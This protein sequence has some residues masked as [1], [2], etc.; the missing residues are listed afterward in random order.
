MVLKSQKPPKN[1]VRV[2]VI[3]AGARDH[4]HL[5]KFETYLHKDRETSVRARMLD[6]LWNDPASPAFAGALAYQERGG[7]LYRTGVAVGFT[8]EVTRWFPS[9]VDALG[10]LTHLGPLSGETLIGSLMDYAERTEGDWE[11]FN[12]I[13]PIYPIER[14]IGGEETFRGSVKRL[15]QMGGRV[16]NRHDPLYAEQLEMKLPKDVLVVSFG[17]KVSRRILQ[18]FRD[19]QAKI[20]E[21]AAKA[22][23]VAPT[24][25]LVAA[26]A[27]EVE[28]GFEL[29]LP[30]TTY[31][32][33]RR[34]PKG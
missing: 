5:Q 9:T 7:H 21:A 28:V 3:P 10:K 26:A 31:I 8:P 19:T 30:P 15:K 14:W 1:P 27:W 25:P 32:K 6:D 22:A 34:E 12:V 4:P 2:S 18:D 17:R 23:A 11:D 29:A 13:Q 24:S 33:L 16:N 20:Q